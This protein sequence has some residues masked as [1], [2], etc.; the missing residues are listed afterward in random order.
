MSDQFL[1]AGNRAWKQ[2]SAG[3]YVKAEVGDQVALV[4]NGE[5][6]VL[7]QD[8]ASCRPVKVDERTLRYDDTDDW[9]EL[10]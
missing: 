9:M 4:T 8:I 3:E 1:H 10:V 7:R 6:P 5:I 2:T